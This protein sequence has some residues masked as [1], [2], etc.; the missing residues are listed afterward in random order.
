LSNAPTRAAIVLPVVGGL[1]EKFASAFR[2]ALPGLSLSVLPPFPG[3]PYNGELRDIEVLF[4]FGQF[5]TDE[6]L[7][8]AL[9]LRLI[10]C[11][12]TGLDG[13]VDRSTL[14][15]A[16]WVTN[17]RGIHGAPVSE[18]ALMLM[19]ALARHVPTLVR[20]QAE[21]RWHFEPARLLSGSTVGILGVGHIAEAL[22]R[23][24]K[25]SDMRVEGISRRS[26]AGGFDRLHAYT[27]LEKVVGGFD[28]FVILA[29]LATVTRNSVNA[30]VL[31]AMKPGSVLINVARGG[32]VDE[33]A[34]VEASRRGV[35]A[36]AGLDVFTEEPLNSASPL[37]DMP[38]VLISPHAAGHHTGYAESVLP[39]VEANWAAIRSG[40]EAQLIN[41]VR[42]PK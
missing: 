29:P 18:T 7:A 21:H 17:A 14:G 2:D 38:N 11:L 35:P 23:R 3:R 15:L 33:P 36:A 19:L 6:A 42:R 40:Q 26:Q 37:W 5:L 24:C 8:D 41:V 4:T 10:Q 31:S 20:A 12:G 27:A 32:I 39:I 1:S 16:T 28:Y 13:I 25:A 30:Q 34:L 9:S 22:A